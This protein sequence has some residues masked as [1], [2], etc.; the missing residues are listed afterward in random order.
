MSGR[1]PT[2]T[3]SPA[4]QQRIEEAA[5]KLDGRHR[6]IVQ[7][8]AN[9]AGLSFEEMMEA[10]KNYLDH[11]EMMINGGDYEGMYADD[12]FWDAYEV[13]TNRTVKP[14]DRGGIFSCAC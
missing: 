3:F 4:E 8:M 2:S 10:A 11:G 14:D 5:N 1:I 13:L 7:A 6:A 9:Q 12:D